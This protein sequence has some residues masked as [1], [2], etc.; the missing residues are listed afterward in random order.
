[1]SPHDGERGKRR[2]GGLHPVADHVQVVCAIPLPRRRGL[3]LLHL[4]RLLATKR[5]AEDKRELGFD[6]GTVPAQR[7][8]AQA[9]SRNRPRHHH[10]QSG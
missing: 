3:K 6:A 9:I 10:L 7:C 5:I 8:R 2:A 1:M 4:G